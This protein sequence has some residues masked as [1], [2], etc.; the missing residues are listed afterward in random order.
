M[1]GYGGK[2]NKTFLVEGTMLRL[3]S[4]AEILSDYPLHRNLELT[5]EA[6]LPLFGL[7]SRQCLYE[8]LVL[9]LVH[10]YLDRD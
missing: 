2:G 4:K 6:R 1:L 10:R 5:V 7:R 9:L 3:T 8:L